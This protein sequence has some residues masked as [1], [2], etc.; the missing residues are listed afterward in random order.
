MPPRKN[1]ASGEPAAKKHGDMRVE[2]VAGEV[3]KLKAVVDELVAQSLQHHNI[4]WR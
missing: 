4:R 2:F 1:I 3:T